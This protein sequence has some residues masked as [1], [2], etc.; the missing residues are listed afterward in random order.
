MG[1]LLEVA[2]GGCEGP[3]D[4]AIDSN[5]RIY[6]GCDGG[7]IKR[8]EPGSTPQAWANTGGRPLGMEFDAD[9]VLWV[10]DA[11]LGLVSVD[12][13]G[14]VQVVATE[15]D[16]QAIVYADD[17]DVARDGRV[18]LSDASSRFSPKD[19]DPLA[20]SVLEIFEHQNT[21]RLLVYEPDEGAARTLLSGLCFAN[22][23]ALAHDESFVL[24]SDTGNYR[25]LRY[26]LSGEMEGREEEL[27]TDLP[28]FPDNIS[29]G[30]E[31]QFW[32]ALTM[33]RS[34]ELD[35]AA[36]SPFLRKV[37]H[38]LPSWAKP[39]PAPEANLLNFDGSGSIGRHFRQEG[40]P[41]PFT[42]AMPR[43]D[44]LYFGTVTGNALQRWVVKVDGASD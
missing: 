24:V 40:I 15:A 30:E 14:E 29:R 33:P 34:P 22:G 13:K 18:F 42:S 32:L 26:W 28:G 36:G 9:G 25:V 19:T 12:P 43:G 10:A 8:L 31:G 27:L 37:M 4:A 21:G 3:E 1:E 39:E 23:I 17:V 11:H 2:T 44:S 20:A 5:G 35:A 6:F 7:D 38:R 16:G 41:H